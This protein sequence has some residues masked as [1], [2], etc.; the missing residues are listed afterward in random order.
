MSKFYGEIGYGEMIETSPGV[1]QERVVKRP[2]Y[3]DVTRVSSN[4]RTGE[5]LNDNITINNQISVIADAFA[6]EKFSNILYVEWMK[7]KWKVSSVEIQQPR[8]VL[9]L[10]EVY[11]EQIK[12]N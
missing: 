11:N 9:T 6:Y 12:E 5:Y 1:W 10:G 2:Y 4:R 3:G 7:V 8:L